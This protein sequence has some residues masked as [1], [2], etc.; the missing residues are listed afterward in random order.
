MGGMARFGIK[1]LL[2]AVAVVALWL[3][4]F[5]GFVG[6]DD[7]RRSILLVLYLAALLN[8]IYSRGRERAFWIGFFAVMPVVFVPSGSLGG[9][10]V[11]QFGWVPYLT[12]PYGAGPSGS[13]SYTYQAI[14]DTTRALWFLALSTTVGYIGAGIYDRTQTAK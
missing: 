11:P 4:T 2:V 8:A 13:P 12:E 6:G 7:V 9:F 1:L 10:F 14:E 3:S 5:S